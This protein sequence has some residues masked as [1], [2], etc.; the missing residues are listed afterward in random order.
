M[1]VVSFDELCAL[2]PG[3]IFQAYKPH[4]IDQLMIFGGAL[5]HGDPHPIDFIQA[6]LTP[7]AILGSYWSIH[8]LKL[9]DGSLT[10]D[11]GIY[12]CTPSDFGRWG[13]Y[14]YD[15]KYVV[16]EK[17]DRERL[18]RWLLD[19]AEALVRMNDDPHVILD[20]SIEGDPNWPDR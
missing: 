9:A 1:R 4:F 8:R 10:S 18:A 15:V 13:L 12:L 20:V 17:E 19:P 16:W 6:A 14:D 7:D 3:T 5:P 2:E 11:D